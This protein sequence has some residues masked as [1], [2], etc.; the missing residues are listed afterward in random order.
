MQ[1]QLLPLLLDVD[2][3]PPRFLPVRSGTPSFSPSDPVGQDSYSF[4]RVPPSQHR[5]SCTTSLHGGLRE[6]L[7][8]FALASSNSPSSLL[9]HKRTT[10]LPFRQAILCLPRSRPWSAS[11]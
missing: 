4:H 9:V 10:P 1:S 11:V 3:E 2:R 6:K 8:H 7:D 5:P